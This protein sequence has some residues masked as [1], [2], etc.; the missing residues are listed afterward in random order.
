M[1]CPRC[2]TSGDGKFCASCGAALIAPKCPSCAHES[3]PGA[4]FCNQC[5]ASLAGGVGQGAAAGAPADSSKEGVTS[6]LGWWMA[7]AML[8]G[9]IL[10]IGWPIYGPGGRTQSPAPAQGAGIVDASSVDLSSMTPRQAADRLYERVMTAVSAGDQGE[11]L[12]FMPMAIASYERAAPLDADGIHHLASLLREAQRHEEALAITLQALEDTP[13][14]LLVL[15]SAA[16]ASVGIGDDDAARG[17]YQHILDVWDAE[18]AK[19]VVDYELHDRLMPSIRS[20]AEG[21]VS[22]G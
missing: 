17:H 8:A 7:G 1:N 14:H 13:D 21:F 3:Q 4:R 22:G 12:R 10:V 19:G 18:M 2:G 16:E 6:N 15:V 5:G 9:L 11:V 20:A